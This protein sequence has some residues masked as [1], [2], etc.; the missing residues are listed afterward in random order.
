MSS[1]HV[2]GA[3][4]WKQRLDARI[5]TARAAVHAWNDDPVLR[6]YAQRVLSKKDR[7]KL[8]GIS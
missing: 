4:G 3:R 2:S 5:R 1:V 6:A 7:K 8:L